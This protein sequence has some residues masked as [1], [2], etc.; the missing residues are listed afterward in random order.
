[1]TAPTNGAAGIIPA[2]LHTY[3]R[4][5]PGA[6]DADASGSCWWVG[7][8][9]SW[10]NGTP[11]SPELRWGCQGEVGSACAMAAAGLC[12]VLGGTPAQVENAAEIGIEHNLGLTCDPVGGLVQIPCIERNAVAAVKAISAA[13]LALHGDGS[14]RV[15]LDQV[16]ATL[17]QTG[18]G[19]AV[20]VQGDLPGGRSRRQRRRLLTSPRLDELPSPPV[21]DS[22]LR[23]VTRLR[24]D[25]LSGVV[26]L[27]NASAATLISVLAARASA[28]RCSAPV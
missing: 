27:L 5:T 14:H 24:A 23:I 8:S 13:Q 20:R 12:E 6:S 18:G 26:V 2:V 15:S 9:G 3:M 22:N 19:H 25:E 17:R 1:M 7:P 21:A 28:A 16:I 4:F 11:R 10:S